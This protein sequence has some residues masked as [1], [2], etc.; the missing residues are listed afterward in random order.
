MD[1]SSPSWMEQGAFHLNL[2]GFHSRGDGWGNSDESVGHLSYRSDGFMESAPSAR[3]SAC[4]YTHDMNDIETSN[5][6][7]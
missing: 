4:M 3:Y 6:T 1:L 2:D 5:P 7:I